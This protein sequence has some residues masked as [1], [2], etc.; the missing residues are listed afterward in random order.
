MGGDIFQ[1]LKMKLIT[2]VFALFLVSSAAPAQVDINKRYQQ[3]D[4]LLKH[5]NVGEAYTIFKEI[6]PLVAKTDTLYNYIVWYYISTATQLENRSRMKEDFSSSLK[7]GLEALALIR[8]NK[9]NF[10]S[11]FAAREPWMIKNVGVSYFGLGQLDEA[12]KYTELLYQGYREK[13]LPK[14][15]D[16]YFNYDFFTL[17]SMNVWGY[18]WYHELPEDRF[19]T[20]FTKIVYY[21]YSRNADGS[22]KDQLYRLH[23]LMFHKIDEKA[24]DYV[25]TKIYDTE[26]EEIAG[27]YFK[28]MYYKDIDYRKLKEDI[29]T[30]IKTNL[31]PD[32]RRITPKRD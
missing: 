19:S 23:V 3:A 32:S 5:D 13:T 15:I 26:K 30:V 18:E 24:P 31:Q 14:G 28:Y 8:E 9:E 27:T 20:S 22:D 11:K 16:G 4:S 10:D 21:V 2:C 17:D 7:Y 25:L 12:K 29:K 1:F 6:K